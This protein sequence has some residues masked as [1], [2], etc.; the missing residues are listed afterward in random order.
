ML[1]TYLEVIVGL[2]IIL[3]GI[4]SYTGS[5]LLVSVSLYFAYVTAH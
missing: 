4:M 1:L 5:S 3:Y 2:I